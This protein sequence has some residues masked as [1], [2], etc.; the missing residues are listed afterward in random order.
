MFQASPLCFSIT[1][2]L[3]REEDN[4]GATPLS[5]FLPVIHSGFVP[6]LPPPLTDTLPLQLP[7]HQ[8]SSY[9][10]CLL[11]S[12]FGVS[13]MFRPESLCH[14][15]CQLSIRLCPSRLLTFIAPLRPRVLFL[16]GDMVDGLSLLPAKPCNTSSHTSAFPAPTN[17]YGPTLQRCRSSTCLPAKPPFLSLPSSLPV[18]S[19]VP[20][21]TYSPSHSLPHPTVL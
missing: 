6:P 14:G 4:R 20:A 21:L 3:R 11:S 19:L 9:R 5:A 8:P 18:L 17:E 10:L 15:L 13:L 16:A 12:F 7:L 1:R 2:S